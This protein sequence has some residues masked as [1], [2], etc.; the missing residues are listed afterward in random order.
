M[1]YFKDQSCDFIRPVLTMGTFDGVH[2]GHEKLLKCAVQKAV[3]K[4]TKSV[5]LSYYHH[6]LETI[7]KK[8]FP[9]LLTQRE[10]KEKLIKDC[11][12]DYVLNLDFNKRIAQMSAQ[13]FLK[14]IIIDKIGAQCLVVGYDTHFGRGREG[15]IQFLKDNA[16]KNY[17]CLEVVEP[18]MMGNQIIS[19]SLIRDYIREGDL[20]KA[21]KFLGHDYSV[22]GF[23][24][25][26]HRIGR[27]MGFPTINVIPFDDNKL[28]P[29]IGVYICKV[30]VNGSK[31]AGV[32]NIGYSPTIKTSRVKQIEMHIL[33][34]NEDVYNKD[35]E[36]CF[37]KRLRD[38]KIFKDKQELINS[39]AADVK[40]T[41]KYFK[42]KNS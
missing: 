35:V 14:Q 21:N 41:R 40:V 19:S 29:A 42:Q 32:T 1:K 22:H 27:E 9:Y 13:D 28:I 24:V 7:H 37:I 26:G 30:F 31:Y 15:N 39:I 23:V 18:V 16:V 25:T 38:E 36:V 8:T 17:Y 3:E 2:L 10:K 4:N 6:P 34:F 5:V 11:G 12:I 33:D 20:V